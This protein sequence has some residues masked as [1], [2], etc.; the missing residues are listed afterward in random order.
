VKIAYINQVPEGNDLEAFMQE[1]RLEQGHSEIEDMGK[2][3][4]CHVISAYDHNRLVAVGFTPTD[5]SAPKLESAEIYVLPAYAKRG[6]ESNV[7]KLL[8]AEWKYCPEAAAH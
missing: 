7:Y 4:S 8:L 6:L 1:Y 3:E 2:H 5:V